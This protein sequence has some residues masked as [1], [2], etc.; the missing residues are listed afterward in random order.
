MIDARH[1]DVPLGVRAR[2]PSPIAPHRVRSIALRAALLFLCGVEFAV[3]MAWLPDTLRQW[4]DAGPLAP[5]D[6]RPMGDWQV[7]YAYAKALDGQGLYSPALSVI[8]H[9]L[10]WLR[11]DVAYRTY[12]A[13]GA[14]CWLALA[15]VAQRHVSSLEAKLAVVLG[16]VSLPQMHWAIRGATLTPFLALATYAGFALLERRPRLGGACLAVLTLKPPFALA[17]FVYLLFARRRAALTS[18]VAVGGGAALVGLAIVG[19]GFAGQY[20]STLTDWGPDQRDNLSPI[21]QTWQHAW[22]GFLRSIGARPHPLIWLDLI[23]A[24]AL[25][26]YL[27][28]RRT[29]ASLHAPAIAIGMLLVTPY[30]MFYDWGLLL[31]PAALLLRAPATNRVIVATILV[32]GYAAAVLTQVA[33]P[34]PPPFPTVEGARLVWPSATYGVYLTA[35]LA[36]AVLAVLAVA[37]DRYAP[38][39]SSRTP[40]ARPPIAE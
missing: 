31:V 27:A 2:W 33:T 28:C 37:G 21:A 11:I 18:F 32:A 40:A 20:I 29:E 3:L 4:A 35:P 19:F 10:T 36:L 30:A 8:Q 15:L 5:N 13:A 25:C 22:P 34:Y 6:N 38:P 16:M 23:A 26:V 24:S 17:P 12:T 14:I 7:F 9:P 39:P 1:L